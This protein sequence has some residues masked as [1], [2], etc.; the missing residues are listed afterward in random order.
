MVF[1]NITNI[2]TSYNIK[3]VIIFSRVSI[4]E[5]ENFLQKPIN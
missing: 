2:L 4:K 5:K 1:I 3:V